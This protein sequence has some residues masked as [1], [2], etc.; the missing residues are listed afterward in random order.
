MV[1][2]WVFLFK[3]LLVCLEES[4]SKAFLEVFEVKAEGVKVSV[5]HSELLQNFIKFAVD[6]LNLKEAKQDDHL[7]LPDDSGLILVDYFE[8]IF[9]A[10][11]KSVFDSVSDSG[12]ES[13]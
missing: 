13:C 12:N 11:R 6:V 10:V 1:L 3:R 2:L 9:S 8:G 7:L 4:I 5:F